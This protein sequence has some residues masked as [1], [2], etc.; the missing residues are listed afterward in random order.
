MSKA[1]EKAYNIIRL[2]V[3]NGDFAPGDRLKEERLVEIC[4]VSRTPVRDAIKRL[5]AENYVV[6]KPNHGGQVADWSPEEIEDIFK[7]RALAEGMA[8]RRAAA[9]ITKDQMA[10]LRQQYEI[11][12]EM[13]QHDGAPNIETFLTANSLFHNT[14]LEATRSETIKQVVFRLVSPPIVY[15]T[16]HRYSRTDLQR[17]NAHHLELID[18]LEERNGDWCDS[19]MQ[20]H[21]LAAH[22]RF[23]DIKK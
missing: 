12:D 1:A 16:A 2:S 20:T 9:L 13:L 3:L 11:I 6:M 22:R 19:V 17:S 5:A 15:Q 4:G 18:A 10:I 8:A 23:K 21:I 7:L 14:I